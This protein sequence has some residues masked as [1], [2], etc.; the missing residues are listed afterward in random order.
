M[1][2]SKLLTVGNYFHFCGLLQKVQSTVWK[3]K[4]QFGR[5]DGLNEY[6]GMLAFFA[7]VKKRCQLFTERILSEEIRHSR[8]AIG[9]TAYL[10]LM[11]YSV[12]GKN[13]FTNQLP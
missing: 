12:R 7:R 1:K 6:S 5:S 4:F 2:R 13:P 9:S 10:R 3:L 8:S 11:F